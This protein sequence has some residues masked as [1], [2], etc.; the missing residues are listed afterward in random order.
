[1][2]AVDFLHHEKPPNSAGVVP[3]SL[4]IQGSFAMRE[5]CGN[6]LV[7]GPDYMVEALKLP[8]QSR[9]VSA[10]SGQSLA[11]NGTVAGSRCLNLV[12][13]HTEATHNKL[14]LSNTT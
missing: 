5:K 13:G 10:V 6:R 4:G 7:P 9:R 1:M 8:N 3:T 14:L 12:F 2:D 11:S